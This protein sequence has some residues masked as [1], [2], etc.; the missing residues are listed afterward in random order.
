MTHTKE[1]AGPLESVGGK[2]SF[3]R[4]QQADPT[5]NQLF[6]QARDNSGNP[7]AISNRLL[8]RKEKDQLGVTQDLLLVPEC[9][10]RRVFEEAHSSP[11]AG[12]FGFKKT[13][14]KVSRHFYWQ[15]ICQDLKLWTK[16]CSTCQK[17]NKT[18][19]LKAPLIP[20][21]VI[22]APWTRVAFDVVGPLPRS[23]KGY[24][25]ILTCMDFASRF[26]EAI[27]LRRVNA[28][29]VADAMIEVFSRYG[30]PIEALTDN[31]TCFVGKLTQ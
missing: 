10:R 29:S 23:K 20:L 14:T 15:G 4:E 17:G 3:S 30:I 28:E 27:P 8:V 12:H 2:K 16:S 1:T 22:D 7:Y 31:G 11:L 5:L 18:S 21:P 6:I 9:H 13:K 24:K 25:Y 19:P 26:P